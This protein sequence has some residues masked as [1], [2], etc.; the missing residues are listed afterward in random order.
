MEKSNN[1]LWAGIG[2]IIESKI[3]L[4]ITYVVWCFVYKIIDI[5]TMQWFGKDIFI[6]GSVFQFLVFS[7]FALA[8]VGWIL[9]L[10]HSVFT[11]KW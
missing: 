2:W 9:G 1:G 6:D 3:R 8:F 10:I 7:I 4:A 5:N 11:G